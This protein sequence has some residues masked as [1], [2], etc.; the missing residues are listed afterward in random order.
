MLVNVPFRQL[1]LVLNHF[2]IPLEPSVN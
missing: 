1:K 2:G